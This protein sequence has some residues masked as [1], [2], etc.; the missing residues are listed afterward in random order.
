MATALTARG[1]VSLP[2]R[3]DCCRAARHLIACRM[4]KSLPAYP[5]ARKP[6]DSGCIRGAPASAVDRANFLTTLTAE[7]RAEGLNLNVETAKE[8][9]RRAEMSPELR[10]SIHATVYRGGDPAKS[11]PMSPTGLTW[12]MRGYPSPKVRTQRWRGA[13]VNE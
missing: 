2:D 7:A 11:R 1:V 8:M 13:S 3:R 4:H 6:Q 10:R 9:E 12:A 5:P